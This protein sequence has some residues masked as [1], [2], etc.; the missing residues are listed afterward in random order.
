MDTRR[1][2]FGAQVLVHLDAGLR[3][4][5]TLVGST[6]RAE[7]VVQDAALRAYRGFDALRGDDA[8]AWFLAIVR[9]ASLTALAHD[10]RREFQSLP[11]GD[12]G[13]E[14]LMD[15]APGPEAACIADQAS[16]ALGAALDALAPA[17]REILLLREVEELDYREIAQVL[18]V[19]IGTVMSRLA[20]ARSALRTQ[21][22]ASQEG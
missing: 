5:K 2:R 6:T 16:D 19:K 12:D 20:R 17:F 11:D 1:A 21:W 22:R 4:A 14:W 13:E 15:S 10:T 3:L 18:G 8:R 9:N 7:D